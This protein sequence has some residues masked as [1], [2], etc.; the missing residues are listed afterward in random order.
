MRQ[1]ERFL[2]RFASGFFVWAWRGI[3][4]AMAFNPFRP[5]AQDQLKRT[6]PYAKREPNYPGFEGIREFASNEDEDF[7]DLL[8]FNPDALRDPDAVPTPE[9]LR[10]TAP[11]NHKP[12]ERPE[13]GLNKADLASAAEAIEASPVGHEDAFLNPL[14][15]LAKEQR[16]AVLVYLDELAKME[17]Y[18]LPGAAGLL[19]KIESGNLLSQDEQAQ[20]VIYLRSW[21]IFLGE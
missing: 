4:C 19:K 16:T 8:T 20:F 13:D 12:K 17:Q 5:L 10:A 2:T 11:D 9:Q 18:R 3:L 1:I 6:L 21:K 14:D 15:Y 7:K